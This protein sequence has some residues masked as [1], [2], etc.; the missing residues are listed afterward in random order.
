MNHIPVLAKEVIE[1][2]N[3]KKDGVYLDCTFGAGGYSKLILKKGGV[4]YAC[5]Q[6]ITTKKHFDELYEQFPSKIIFFHTNFNFVNEFLIKNNVNE[7]DGIVMDLGVSSM[8]IDNGDRGFS[9]QKDGPLDM[10]MDQTNDQIQSAK[11]FVN[12]A[13]ENDLADVIY[14]YGDERDARKIARAIVNARE[15]EEIL[16]TSQLSNIVKK[17]KNFSFK[18][19]I[20]PST[21]TFQAIR[22][23]VNNEMNFLITA[24][25]KLSKLLSINGKILVV[26][27]HSIEDMVVKKFFSSLDEGSYNTNYDLLNENFYANYKFKIE[28]KVI[29][30]SDDEI[31]NNIRSR[32]AK[33]R[34]V[35]RVTHE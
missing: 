19:K 34:I 10:R 1:N 31:K 8:Q 27:F 23:H 28:K 33:L 24:L 25:Q 18:Q 7:L 30:P 9:F 17:V 29:T 4:V 11:D 26:T 20:D 6:D 16:T 22:I 32:S 21:K 15:K 3:V 2:L 12:F 5:D 13:S 14:Y 35:Q